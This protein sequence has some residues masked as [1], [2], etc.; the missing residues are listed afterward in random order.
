VSGTPVCLCVPVRTRVVE[1]TLR[2]EV[3]KNLPSFFALNSAPLSFP[4]ILPPPPPYP[5]QLHRI[6]LSVSFP[7]LVRRD[8]CRWNFKHW[9]S[10]RKRVRLIEMD[11]S[12]SCLCDSQYFKGGSFIGILVEVCGRIKLHDGVNGERIILHLAT[13]TDLHVYYL[14]PALNCLAENTY[15]TAYC[16]DI[17]LKRT[18]WNFEGYIRI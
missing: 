12:L 15:G 13:S 14:F 18:S 8:C 4:F 5:L 10:S 9:C 17:E 3:I 2:S 6:V 1:E 16:L 11:A 7:P